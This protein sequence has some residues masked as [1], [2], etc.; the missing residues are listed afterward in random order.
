MCKA[1]PP[2]IGKHGGFKCGKAWKGNSKGAGGPLSYPTLVDEE[3]LSW[4]PIMNDFH[5]P[6]SVLALQNKAKS[7]ILP[8]KPSPGASRGWI[9][10]SKA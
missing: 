1:S 6:V 10:Q 4:I 8:H 2:E 3:L 5:L 9:C 7:L